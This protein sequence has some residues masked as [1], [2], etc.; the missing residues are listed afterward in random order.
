MSTNYKFYESAA[1]TTTTTGT[2]TVTLS[3]TNVTGYRTISGAATDADKLYYRIE[4]STAANW[5][6]GKGVYT[7]LG[8]TLSRVTV[9]ASSNSNAA[10]SFAAGTKNVYIV[11]PDAAIT[12]SVLTTSGDI[13]YHDGTALARLGAGTEGY[14]LTMTSGVPAWGALANY[15]SKISVAYASTSALPANTYSNGSSGVGAT[16]TGNANGPLLIDG[17]TIITGQ[18]G[19][20]V[21]VAG[22]ATQANNGW[23][24][25]TQIGVVA[26]SPYI[27]TRATDS[28]QAAEIGAGYLTSVTAPNTVTPGSSNNGKIFISVA[29]DPFTVGTT[30]LTFSQ[31]GSTYSAGTGLSLSG[32]TF[33][34]TSP[35][36]T[37]TGGTGLTSITTGD[38]LYGSASNVISKLGIGATNSYLTVISGAPAWTALAT[39]SSTPSDQTAINSATE[40][41]LGLAGSITPTASGKIMVTICGDIINGTTTAL[42]TIRIHYGTGTAPV[43][44][45]ATTG[46]SI[47]NIQV[48]RCASSNQRQGFSITAIATGLTPSTAYWIDLGV[49]ASAGIVTI[50]NV[51]ISAF[52]F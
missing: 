39:A 28:D 49:F 42:G 18:V 23:Y 1:E 33:S 29:A 41:M 4:D 36:A 47:G 37:T 31:V 38:L 43:N 15:D 30:A 50:R 20:R 46:T 22:E 17:V 24:T 27:L 13:P 12:S 14:V 7:A 44:A 19:S 32:T 9:I 26:V 25:I 48:C 6:V 51:A 16:L 40:L 10:V 52:E 21:L 34:L 2:G 5:E 8:T 45:A 11:Q 3:G 35:V